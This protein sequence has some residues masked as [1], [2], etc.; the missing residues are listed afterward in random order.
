[1]AEEER[2][3]VA[4]DFGVALYD[5]ETQKAVHYGQAWWA[6]RKGMKPYIKGNVT[7][8]GRKYHMALAP[9]R[10]D[11]YPTTRIIHRELIRESVVRAHE[12][13]DLDFEPEERKDE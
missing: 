1:M 4:G 2:P 12:A 3:K 8:G 10:A 13:G 6:L 11:S 7:I 5:A 9:H